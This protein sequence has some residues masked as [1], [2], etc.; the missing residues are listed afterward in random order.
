MSV[1]QAEATG[2]FMFNHLMVEANGYLSPKLSY[3]YVQRLN[4]DATTYSLE[5]L[6]NAI[7]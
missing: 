1:S 6:N 4:K 3:R 2:R 7:D 5:N